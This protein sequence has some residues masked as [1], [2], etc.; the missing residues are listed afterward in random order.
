MKYSASKSKRFFSGP[1]SMRPCLL[2]GRLL[3]CSANGPLIFISK[4]LGPKN[5]ILGRFCFAGP[6]ISLIGRMTIRTAFVRRKRWKKVITIPEENSEI[7]ATLAAARALLKS[8]W[9]DWTSTG[10][11]RVWL[12]LVS[13]C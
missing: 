13:V 10:I 7:S 4:S 9:R 5:L 2:S 12:L 1:T 8:R 3:V 11:T 6:F